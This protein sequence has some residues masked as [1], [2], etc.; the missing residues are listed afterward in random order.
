LHTPFEVLPCS[1]LTKSLPYNTWQ[2]QFQNLKIMASLYERVCE[3]KKATGWTHEQISV[4][5]GL[6]I[7]TVS[8]IFR[9]PE[10]TGNKTSNQL[11]K[12]LYQEV[13]KSPFPAYIEQ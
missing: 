8:R 2:R 7:S 13:V 12:Q 1:V 4:E 6:H 9:V 5:T 10:Y 11:V 3:I